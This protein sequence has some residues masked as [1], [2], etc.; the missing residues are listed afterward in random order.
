MVQTRIEVLGTGSRIK[1][2]NDVTHC[3]WDLEQAQERLH[4]SAWED[5]L[6]ENTSIFF[7]AI[8]VWEIY[9]IHLVRDWEESI[10]YLLSMPALVTVQHSFSVLHPGYSILYPDPSTTFLSISFSYISRSSTATPPRC[11]SWMRVRFVHVDTSSPALELT[12]SREAI[13]HR[14]KWRSRQRKG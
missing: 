6:H 5:V 8:H 4:T 7:V 2:Q 3:G 10:C 9:Q 14:R 12:S 1:N 11:H 13:Q